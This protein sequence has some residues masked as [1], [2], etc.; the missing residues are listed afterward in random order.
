MDSDIKENNNNNIDIYVSIFQDINRN[1]NLLR[2]ILFDLLN[3]YSSVHNYYMQYKNFKLYIEREYSILFDIAQNSKNIYT[4]DK[5]LD[6]KIN[7]KLPE[8]TFFVIGIKNLY[9]YK[10]IKFITKEIINYDVK[11]LNYLIYLQKHIVTLIN[12]MNQ[13]NYFYCYCLKIFFNYRCKNDNI[14]F[15]LIDKFNQLRYDYVNNVTKQ[16]S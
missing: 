9:K 10:S 11:I 5:K 8:N 14:N 15:I 2:I 12:G 16:F 13:F 1:Y 6:K 3:F 4:I 7:S